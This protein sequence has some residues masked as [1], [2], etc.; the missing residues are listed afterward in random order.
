[1]RSLLGR[2]RGARASTYGRS[3]VNP[4]PGSVLIMSNGYGEDAIACGIVESLQRTAPALRVLA[5]PLV[6]EGRAYQ[7]LGV[8]VVGPRVLLPSGG[9]I[10][11]G[12][13]NILT[14]MRAGLWRVTRGH[15][16]TL[17]QLGPHLG[18]LVACGDTYPVL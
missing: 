10:L 2:S 13:T 14:D 18:A 16:K 15:I 6:G 8:E 9:L 11:A 4:G 5:M 3:R 1:M 12:W 17:R 7:H